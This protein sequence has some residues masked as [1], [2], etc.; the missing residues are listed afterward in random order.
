MT[1]HSRAMDALL[2]QM[3]ER[4]A[5]DLYLQADERPWM[6]VAGRVEPTDLPAPTLEQMRSYLDHVLTPVARTR[7]ARTSDIDAAYTLEGVGRFRINCFFQQGRPA[8]AVRL[9]PLGAVDFSKLN[10][11]D[12]IRQM[13]D[14]PQGLVLV[15]GP[16]G[17]GKSTTLAALI[18]H[19]NRSRH[20]HIV[21]IE[22]PIEFVH[23]QANCL[24][25]QRQVGYDTE[26]FDSAL[27]H[28]VRQSPD[29]ILIG[30]MRDADTMTTALSAALTGHLVL[31]TLHTTNVSQSI[32]RML[33]YFD[34]AGRKQAR[35]DLAATL[36]GMVSMR[37]LTAQDGKG[38]VP[39][40]EVLRGTP[41]VRRIIS[42]GT[43]SELYD[44]MKRGGDAGM[45]T[46]NQSLVTLVRSGR[47]DQA[48]AERASANVD[49]LRLN[50][51]GMYTG[52]DSVRLTGSLDEEQQT[53]TRRRR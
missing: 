50:L 13:A 27:R 24:I 37:L 21:T 26:S 7:F 29:T 33:N 51:Q 47:I 35:Y 12:T 11:P 32:E 31:S 34:P 14:A 23:E 30:E 3:V 20:E 25:H 18:H 4:K 15:V 44:V 28:V 38:R 9:I 45:M 53:P 46:L 5:S 42:E 40:V 19:I 36:V 52:V 41:T 39:A 17:C 1:D 43:L 6:R 2:G 10:L 22:D 8:M 49:E 16:T 48:T